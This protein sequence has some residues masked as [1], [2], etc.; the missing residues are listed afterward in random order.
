METKSLYL[1]T[2]DPAAQLQS[3]NNF[4]VNLGEKNNVYCCVEFFPQWLKMIKE[5]LC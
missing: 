2:R 4:S 1:E 5:E 3:Y